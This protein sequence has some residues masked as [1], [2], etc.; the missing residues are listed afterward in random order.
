MEVLARS[1]DF[2]ILRESSVLG[3]VL[4]TIDRA[5]AVASKVGTKSDAFIAHQILLELRE[6][7]PV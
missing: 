2:A 3:L 4:M 7:C 1:L 6:V 5:P